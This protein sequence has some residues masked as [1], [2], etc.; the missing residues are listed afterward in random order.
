MSDPKPK[1]EQIFVR[2]TPEQK[3]AF[4][5]KAAQYEPL[6]ASDVLRELVVGFSEDR[7]T[8]VP[9]PD[10]KESLYNVPRIQD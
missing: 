6:T 10:K 8:I 2:V 5:S 4:M 7:V 3:A 9:P 1:S